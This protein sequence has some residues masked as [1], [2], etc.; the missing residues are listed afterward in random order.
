MMGAI[1]LEAKQVGLKGGLGKIYW[2]RSSA[3]FR[4]PDSGNGRGALRVSGAG[5]CFCNAYA[6]GPQPLNSFQKVIQHN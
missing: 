6:N 4:S 3:P 2:K 5:G 1:L